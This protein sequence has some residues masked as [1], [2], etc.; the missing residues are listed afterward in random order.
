MWAATSGGDAGL[1]IIDPQSFIALEI[2]RH[3][4]LAQAAQQARQHR[5]VRP[6]RSIRLRLAAWATG[7]AVHA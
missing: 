7:R 2:D 6:R 5:T 4:A 3:L 1:M